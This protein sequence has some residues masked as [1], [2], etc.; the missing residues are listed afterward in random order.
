[1]RTITR[2]APSARQR[3]RREVVGVALQHREDHVGPLR[4]GLRQRAAAVDREAAA[5][6]V[7]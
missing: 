1:M 2:P 7:L 6:P 4:L 3:G 5:P